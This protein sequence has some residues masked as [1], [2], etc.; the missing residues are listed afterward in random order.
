[1]VPDAL[2]DLS[3]VTIRH[4]IHLVKQRL[5]AGF[6]CY[7]IGDLFDDFYTRLA[8]YYGFEIC[9]FCFSILSNML[10]PISKDSSGNGQS[11]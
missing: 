4:V 6:S 1:M 2:Y 10:T 7:G 5:K 9:N 3:K 8:L 11:E